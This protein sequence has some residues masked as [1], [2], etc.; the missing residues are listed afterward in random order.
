MKSSRVLIVDDNQ[1]FVSVLEE[2]LSEYEGFDVVGKAY[3]VGEALSLV[4]S[5]QPTLMIVDLSMPDVSGFELTSRVRQ[6]WPDMALVVLTLLDT[7]HHRRAALAAGA[8]ALIGKAYLD[9][10]LIPTIHTVLRQRSPHTA[11]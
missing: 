9:T 4:P 8:D 5:V 7:P 3:S 11:L 2:F 6:Q 10:E 1:G